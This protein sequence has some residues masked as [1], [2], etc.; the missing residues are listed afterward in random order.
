MAT[1]SGLFPFLG[2]GFA[3]IFEQI[4]SIRVMTLI[5]KNVMASRLIKREKAM[6]PL[7]TLHKMLQ[8][9][10]RRIVQM[11]NKQRSG[12]TQSVSPYLARQHSLPIDILVWYLDFCYFQFSLFSRNLD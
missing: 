3:Q 1:G 2:G 5:N 12:L 10:K 7:K 4:V 8:L 11:R 6:L 9:L